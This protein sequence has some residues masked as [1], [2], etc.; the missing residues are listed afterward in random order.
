MP[1]RV[2]GTEITGLKI[3]FLNIGFIFSSLVK[4]TD[5]PVTEIYGNFNRKNSSNARITVYFN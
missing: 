5:F 3:V 4:I 2:N 1:I